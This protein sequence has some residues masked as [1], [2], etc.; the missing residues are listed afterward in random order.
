LIYQLCV[1]SSHT[2]N[3]KYRSLI[4]CTL[5][6]PLFS[7]KINS[8]AAIKLCRKL[9]SVEEMKLENKLKET[10]VLRKSGYLS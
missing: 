7:N 3:L 10:V 9:K 5:L 8:N 1:E 6:D 2:S 4:H